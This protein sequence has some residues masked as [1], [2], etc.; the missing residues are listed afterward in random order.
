MSLLA[1]YAEDAGAPRELLTD[2]E[3]IARRLAAAGVSFERWPL[4][5]L[6]AQADAA[7]VLAAYAPQVERLKALHGFASV[8]VAALTPEHPQAAE[9]RQKFLAEHTHDDFEV[10]FFVGG[11]GLFYLHPG[12]EVLLLLCE[13]GDLI[14]VPA[15]TPHW[16]DMGARPAFRC[17]RFFTTPEGWVG[18]PS[19]SDIAAR[20]PDFDAFVA[21]HGATGQ[22][23]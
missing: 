23:A 10:R 17:I 11:R 4:A 1:S 2:A 20:F 14:S 22:G 19:G 9:M 13:A 3:A 5:E 6:P 15:G 16:F 8:D 18:R 12:D 21:A 7:A